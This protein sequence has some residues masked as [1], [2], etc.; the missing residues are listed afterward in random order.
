MGYSIVKR[1]VQHNDG[2]GHVLG[3]CVGV[4]NVGQVKVSF[5]R[6]DETTGLWFIVALIFH[7]LIAVRIVFVP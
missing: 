5:H 2:R 7:E 3:L 4:I 1:T 6:L